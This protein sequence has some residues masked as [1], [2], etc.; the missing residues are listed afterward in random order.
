MNPHSRWILRESSS[1]PAI[2]RFYLQ[3]FR[4]SPMTPL[5]KALV[6][7]FPLKSSAQQRSSLHRSITPRMVGLSRLLVT[8]S[9]LSTL[10]LHGETRLLAQAT[11]SRGLATLT[12]TLFSKASFRFM[13]SRTS[14]NVLVPL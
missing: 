10:L 1:I 2:M 3:T 14:R 5:L 12:P 11:H 8:E 9:I 4:P 7:L 6:Y 13:S